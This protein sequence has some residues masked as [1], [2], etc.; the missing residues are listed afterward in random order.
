MI[1]NSTHVRLYATNLLASA[2]AE[3]A[4]RATETL[5]LTKE[6]AAVCTGCEALFACPATAANFEV[7][8]HTVIKTINHERAGEP[9]S[10]ED[11]C[12]LAPPEHQ[13]C[14]RRNILRNLRM[15][16]WNMKST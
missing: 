9:N 15:L 4:S 8:A 3:R 16:R 1:V 7:G 2:K 12:A 14:K 10:S 5:S 6:P 11:T 13:R